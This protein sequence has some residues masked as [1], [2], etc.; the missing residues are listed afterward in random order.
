MF[1]SKDWW[2]GKPY[3]VT[4]DEE[5]IDITDHMAEMNAFA[6][7]LF[8]KISLRPMWPNWREAPV[9]PDAE[10]LNEIIPLRA[11]EPMGSTIILAGRGRMRLKDWYDLVADD[12]TFMP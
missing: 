12:G 5:E 10:Q 7:E 4:D 11:Y 6:K 1:A 3:D 2:D 8:S 9:D